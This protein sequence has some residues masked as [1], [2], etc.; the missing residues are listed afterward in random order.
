MNI[1]AYLL[2]FN[3]EPIIAQTIEFYRQFCSRIFVMDNESTD[4]S[5]AIARSYPNVEVIT[6]SSDGIFDRRLAARMRSQTYRTY[7]RAGHK[8]CREPADWIIVSDMDEL[9]Y[10]PNLPEV[11]RDYRARGVTVP[12]TTGFEMVGPDDLRTDTPLIGQ[13]KKGY[14]SPSMDKRLVFDARFDMSYSHGCHPRGPGFELMKQSY[15]YKSSNEHPIAVLHYKHIGSRYY[16]TA[17]KNFQRAE[18]GSVTRSKDGRYH[19]VGCHYFEIVEKRIKASPLLNDAQHVFA[20]DRPGEV[21]FEHFPA[22][23]GDAGFGAHR[24]TLLP[25]TEIEYLRDLAIRLEQKDL[26]TSLRLMEIA[27]AACPS[28]HR[29]RD[30]VFEYR[31]ALK[32]H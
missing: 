19:G 30:K 14:R 27:H 12:H 1:H 9:V 4:R 17:L 23:C 32:T 11:L 7:S 5:A 31:L 2:C 15:G 29:I 22:S 28:G 25:D 8:Q 18:P 3:E 10:H 20:A 6:W 13:F 21:L 24:P 26:P 16:A